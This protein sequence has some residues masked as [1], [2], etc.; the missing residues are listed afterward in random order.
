MCEDGLPGRQGRRLWAY[1]VL[2]RR[3]PMARD[4]LAAA[5]WAD[6]I[7][8]AW[9]SGL[10]ALVSRL[11]GVLREL[12]GPAVVIRGEPG[13]YRLELPTDTFIDIERASRALLRA[14]A[15]LKAAE[16][17]PAARE[18]LIARAIAGR[19]F[20]AGETGLWVEAQRRVLADTLLRATEMA[21]EAEILRGD[22]GEGQRLAR[23][24]VSLDPLREAG[25]RVLMRALAAGGN[26]AQAVRVMD[27]CRRVLRAEAAMAPCAETERVFREVVGT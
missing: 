17:A 23:E 5:I 15:A 6:G 9:D 21:A 8:D 13:R 11:R 26:R 27:E 14:S 2:E 16:A 19:G 7:P 25:Y 18:A 3:R 24:L 1:L 20:L 22:A 10:N 4:E 12:A